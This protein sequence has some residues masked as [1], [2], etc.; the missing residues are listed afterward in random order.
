M[1]DHV[2]ETFGLSRRPFDKGID[3]GLLWMDGGRQ[4]AL[5]RL[6]QTVAHRQHALVVGEPGVGKTCVL[7][8]LKDQLSP[9]HFRVH[10]LA[11]VTLG[12]R[13]FY[14]QLCYVLGIEH[15]ATPAGMFEAIQRECATSASE[16]R[17]HAVLVLDEAHLLPDPT[18]AHLHVL[19][20][21]EWDSAPLL[22][23]VFVG[24]PELHDRLRLGIHRALL[25]RVH[26]KV[27]LS[28]GSPDL[29]AAYVRKRMVDAGART[30][31]FTAD[32][33]AQLHELTGGLL[34]SVDVLALAALRLAAVEEQA[35]ID[36]TL[37][38]RA[39]AHTPL[40]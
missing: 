20:N 30:E 28:P 14:R 4:A 6:L 3:A 25:T 8:A 16:H 13:D 36:R 23:L 15:K 18:L 10:Y 29:T 35:L 22:S 17:Q 19:A 39:L 31:V 34:R 12:R 24:L 1:S 32:G 9:V 40:S 27:E 33:L 5:D 2:Q 7:R 38:R 11:H 37:I 21:F 26:T